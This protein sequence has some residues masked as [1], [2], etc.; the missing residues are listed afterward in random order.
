LGAAV[1]IGVAFGAWPEAALVLLALPFLAAGLWG[2]LRAPGFTFGAFLLIPYYKGAVQPF[3]PIDL[4]VALVLLNALQLIP[5]V[6]IRTRR[7]SWARKPA[8]WRQ[9]TLLWPGIAVLVVGGALY[10]PEPDLA[11]EMVINFVLLVFVPALAAIRVAADVRYLR[12]LLWTTWVLGVIATGMGLVTLS[13]A[14]RLTV[15][16]GNTILAGR[17]MLF[18]LLI[19]LPFV[20]QVGTW[21]LRAACLALAPLALVLSAATGSRGPIL[22]LGVTAVLFGFRRASLVF[23]RFTRDRQL[24]RIAVHRI[25]V[26]VVGVILL[27]IVV[28]S[29]AFAHYLPT[30]SVWRFKALLEFFGAL[31]GGGSIETAADTSSAGRVLAFQ[32]SIEMFERAPI[33]G[34]GT[35]AFAS[36]ARSVPGI[37]LFTY[38]HNLVLEIAAN[39]GL[40]GVALFSV[41]FVVALT[42]GLRLRAIREWDTVTILFAFVFLNELISGAVVESRLFW[43]LLVLLLAAPVRVPGRAERR[44]SVG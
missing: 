13:D 9:A 28:Q 35:A 32:H 27:W 36:E 11:L 26:V 12:Q 2:L 1:A 20:M 5:L 37:E 31:G 8:D 19:G 34:Q 24:P 41:A 14:D 25:A 4:T 39:H 21:P 17:A 15:L 43:G 40:V 23:G 38:P 16:G 42:K 10:A 22:M 30:T 29:S 33:L 6:R 44:W 3:L 7:A 18:V